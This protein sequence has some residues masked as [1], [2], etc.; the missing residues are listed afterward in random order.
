M[1]KKIAVLFVLIMILSSMPVMAAAS[2][3]SAG[4]ASGVT[5]QAAKSGWVKS[6][7]GYMFYV[8][9]NAYKNGIFWING[10]R[11]GFDANGKLCRGWFKLHGCTY[12]ASNINGA[13]GY[14]EVLTGYRKIGDKFYYLDP[15]KSGLR[16]SGFWWLGGKLYFFSYIDFSQRRTKGWFFI[17]NTMYY[18]KADGTIAT[19]TTIDGYKIGGDGAV[20]DISGMDKKAQGYSSNTRYL[21]L[22]NK[23]EHKINIYQGSKGS[24]AGVR[25]NMLCTI[26]K[27]STPSPSGSFRL[28]HK[29]S[30]TYGYKDFKNSTAFFATRISAGNYFHSILF[31]K[32]CRNPYTHSPK[33]ASLGKSKSNS[34]IRL[35][36]ENARFIHQVTPKNTRVIVY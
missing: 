2:A 31:K 14:G 17:G 4:A 7:T 20:T 23:K 15:Q 11:Y 24:W 1:K 34:C 12:F 36:V 30:K 22:V 19:N 26:G 29:S 33:D 18:V 35:S 32:G 10:K 28:D 13:K 16:R 3:D 21:I 9:G 5:V 8:N 27:S 6:G 25:R